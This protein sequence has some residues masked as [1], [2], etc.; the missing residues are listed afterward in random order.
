MF[1]VF[2]MARYQPQDKFARRAHEQGLP[3]RAAF[4]LE[5]LIERRR[6]LRRDSRV[7]DLGCAPGGWLAILARHVGAQGRIVGIDLVKCR[8]PAAN[9]VTLTGDV[10]ET[11]VRAE[12]IQQLGGAADLITSDLAPKLSGI[13]EQD[14]ARQAELVELA[15]MLARET[16]T[17]RGAMLAKAFMGAEFEAM[18]RLFRETFAEVEV[19]H[20][21]ATRPGSSELYLAGRKLRFAPN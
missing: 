15:V 19:L 14:Q 16:L 10:R 11:S 7:I 5:E 2:V 4:K 18:R 12:I 1:T 8:A 17:S 13:R 9:V 20:T 6:L 21:R 3:S